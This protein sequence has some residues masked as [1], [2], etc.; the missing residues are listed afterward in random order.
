MTN[1]EFQK[2]VLLKEIL[3]AVKSIDERLSK[4]EKSVTVIEYDHG[5]KISALFDGYSL[6]GDQTERLKE[7]LDERLDSIYCLSYLPQIL[8]QFAKNH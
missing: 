7:H 8:P 2:L 1:E 4:V 5:S 3:T 6:R